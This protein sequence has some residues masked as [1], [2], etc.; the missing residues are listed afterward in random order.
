[1]S[2]NLRVSFKDRQYM[3]ISEALSNA[4][5]PTKRTRTEVSHEELQELVVSS[6][7]E[8]DVCPTEDRTPIGSCYPQLDTAA[9]LKAITD[10][11]RLLKE[12]KKE[13]KVAKVEACRM[14]EEKEVVEAKCKDVDQEKYQLRKDYLSGEDDAIVSG[15][16]QENKNPDVVVL[17]QVRYI[18]RAEQGLSF[19]FLN[20][21]SLAL[22]D[23]PSCGHAYL[24]WDNCIHPIRANY[25]HSPQC[26]WLRVNDRIEDFRGHTRNGGISLASVTLLDVVFS[27]LFHGGPIVPL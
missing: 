13:K 2:P 25:V 22:D 20:F 23:R 1:M 24:Y 3:R 12:T 4:P 8:K 17:L 27:V 18:P 5:P 6:S 21:V 10:G 9:K 26:K 7:T 14:G 19:K 11:E 16:T 15:L